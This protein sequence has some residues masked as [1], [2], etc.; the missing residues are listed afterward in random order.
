MMMFCLSAIHPDK[1]T[2]SIQNVANVMR[3]GGILWF[4]DYAENDGAQLKFDS[5]SRISKNFYMRKDGTRSYFFTS[6]V[7]NALMASCNLYPEDGDVRIIERVILNRKKNENM[8]RAWIHGRYRK[9][10]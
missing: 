8:H 9:R 10:N 6:E 3:D 4:R 5:E 2:T 1:M 7:L